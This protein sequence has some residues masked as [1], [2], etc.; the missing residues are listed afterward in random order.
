MPHDRRS[1][2]VRNA[3][4]VTD[5]IPGHPGA[6]RLLGQ[7]REL[8]RRRR[9]SYRTEQAYVG[10]A[11]RFFAHHGW[12]PPLDV[13]ADG[14]RTFLSYLACERSVAASTRNQALNAL[15]FLVQEVR[16]HSLDRLFVRLGDVRYDTDGD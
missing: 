2:I 11:K 8:C 6:S 4:P 10:W 9:L 5:A 12:R 13:G 14:V 15:V 7:F 3:G 16:G 1:S